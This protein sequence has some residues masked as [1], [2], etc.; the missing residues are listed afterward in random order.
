LADFHEQGI[1]GKHFADKC[2]HLWEQL[3]NVVFLLMV[4]ELVEGSLPVSCE[5]FLGQKT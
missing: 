2:L 3:T 4:A 5:N 1:F